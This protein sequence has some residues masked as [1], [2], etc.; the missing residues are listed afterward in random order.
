[1]TTQRDPDRL[2]QLFLDEGPEVLPDR[3]L[4]GVRDDIH[5]IRQRAVFGPRRYFSMRM[6]L[7]S[8]AVVA[9]VLA[10]GGIM[11]AN[12]DSFTGSST[13][14]PTASPSPAEPVGDLIPGATYR[15]MSFSQP[16]TFTLPASFEDGDARGDVWPD[17]HT[18]DLQVGSGGAVTFHDET[19]LTDDPCHITGTIP[20]VPDDVEGWLTGSGG[21]TV[22]APGQISGAARSVTYWDIELGANCFVGDP[23][24]LPSPGPGVWFCSRERHRVY[25]VDL[26]SDHLLVITWPDAYC[27][28]GNDVVDKLNRLT[29]SLVASIR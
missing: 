24:D 6:F 14:S 11:W 26:G 13:P 9:L 23:A 7:G 12:R 5:R 21:S 2:L 19:V 8:A 18:F 4:D 28:E 22:S 17:R 20:D 1:M 29:D 10:A 15:P 25:D 3:V 27:G 16:F